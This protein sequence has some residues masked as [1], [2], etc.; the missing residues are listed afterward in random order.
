MQSATIGMTAIRAPSPYCRCGVLK[1]EDNCGVRN[2]KT[3][4][5]F[6]P[7]CLACR[8]KRLRR[9]RL[10]NPANA[11]WSAAKNRATRAGLSFDLTVEDIVIPDVCPV[12]GIPLIWAGGGRTDNTPS[13]D[14]QIPTLGY[15]RGNIVVISWRANRLK[16]DASPDELQRLAAYTLHLSTE[17]KC[18]TSQ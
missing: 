18:P 1:T 8:A 9:Y 15:V 13:V 7:A 5:S 11:L 3:G 4:R 12:F 2:L 10:Q 6:Q 14:R 16:N 17:P